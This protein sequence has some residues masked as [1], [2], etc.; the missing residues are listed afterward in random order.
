[1]FSLLSKISLQQE[2][3]KISVETE[4]IK[5]LKWCQVTNK[6]ETKSMKSYVVH[7]ISFQP[8][9]V[10]AFRIVEDTWTFS[11]LLLYILWED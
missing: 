5:A 11:I 6:S 8:F 9:F 2:Y 7:S 3:L 4:M 1:M 10:Q